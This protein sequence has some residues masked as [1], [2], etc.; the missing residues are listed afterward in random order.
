MLIT[1]ELLKKH[2]AHINQ[3]A[4]FASL[5]PDGLE[6]SVAM[7][8]E[9]AAAGLNVWWTWHLLPAEGPGSQ[10]AYALWCAEQVAH[11]SDDQRVHD[12]LAVVRRMV[13]GEPVSETE[14]AGAAAWAASR[15]AMCDAQLACLAQLL[16][17]AE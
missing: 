12:C 3:V 2:N 10:R 7:L 4:L 9:A 11:L 17:E 8:S 5:Y 16:E 13:A 1:T 6:P 14:R 15:Q